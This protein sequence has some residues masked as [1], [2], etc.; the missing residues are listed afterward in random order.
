MAT[1]ILRDQKIWFDGYDLSGV[2]NAVRLN[3]EREAKE[4]TVFGD[5][6]RKNKAGLRAV[7]AGAS[8]F[9]DAQPYDAALFSSIDAAEKIISIS[10]GSSAGLNAYMFKA[11][12]GQYAAN[13]QVGEMF[14]Y[15][16]EAASRERLIRSKIMENYSGLDASANGTARQIGAVA[17]GKKA[18]AVLHVLNASGT[19]PTL[20]VTIESDNGSGFA[21]PTTRL[22]FAQADSIG[23]QWQEISGEI[24][25]DYWRVVSAIGGTDPSFDFVVLLGIL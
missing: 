12:I 15:S 9:F 21:T 11:A 19:T 20:D 23:A 24:T 6:T 17:A 18:Y 3:Y 8:G 4:A 2:S 10:S 14:E 16:M 22:T 1:E 13:G 25:D 7:S 5:A